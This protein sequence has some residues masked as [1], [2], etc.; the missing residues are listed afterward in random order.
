[1]NTKAHRNIFEYVYTHLKEK[2]NYVLVNLN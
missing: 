1:M 2:K